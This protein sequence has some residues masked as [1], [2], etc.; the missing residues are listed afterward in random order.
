MFNLSAGEIVVLILLGVAFFGPSKL[1]DLARIH[2]E[3]DG[4]G[5]VPWNRFKWFLVGGVLVLGFLA[6]ALASARG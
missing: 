5:H 1:P 6:I 3:A 2:R 4:A